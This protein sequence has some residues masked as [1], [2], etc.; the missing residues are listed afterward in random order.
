MRLD[1][2]LVGFIIL[3]VMIV[4]GTLMIGSY[5]ESYDLNMSSDEFG[6]VY[7]VI[8]EMQG[9]KDGIK[10]DTLNADISDTDSW[11][12]MTKGSYSALR[13]TSN[14]FS[15]FNN[16][17]TAISTTLGIPHFFVKAAFIAF[18]ILVIFAIVYLVFRVNP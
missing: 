11:E 8:D 18:S 17:L 2:M 10:D 5:N 6:E 3:S 15:L 7:D 14:S 1:S 16:I 13:L 4:G 12:S 9:T